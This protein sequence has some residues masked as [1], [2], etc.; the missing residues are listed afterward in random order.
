[1]GSGVLLQIAQRGEKFLTLI[2]IECFPIVQAYVGAE[3]AN[4]RQFN[5]NFIFLNFNL[6]F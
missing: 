3:S 2:A 1:M 6:R 5:V 4:E